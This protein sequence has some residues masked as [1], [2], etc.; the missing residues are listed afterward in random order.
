LKSD[1]QEETQLVAQKIALTMAKIYP[2]SWDALMEY[3]NE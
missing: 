2:A 1:T 3:M